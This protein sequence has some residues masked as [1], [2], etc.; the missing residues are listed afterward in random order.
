MPFNFGIGQGLGRPAV[1]QNITVRRG[2]DLGGLVGGTQLDD[3]QAQSL[4]LLQAMPALQQAG[5]QRTASPMGSIAGNLIPIFGAMIYAKAAQQQAAAKAQQ[6]AFENAVTVAKLQQG[7]A[8]RTPTNYQQAAIQALTQGDYGKFDMFT[9]LAKEQGS[10]KTPSTIGLVQQANPNATPQQ[11]LDKL[12]AF[13]AQSQTA[14]QAAKAPGVIDQF[15]QEQQIKEGA[16]KAPPPEL[17][18]TWVSGL[19]AIRS[20]DDAIKGFA[21]TTPA[22]ILK[23]TLTRGIMSNQAL[24][25][26]NKFFNDID[27]LRAGARGMTAAALSRVSSELPNPKMAIPDP[28]GFMTQLN[29]ARANFYKDFTTGLLIE[30]HSYKVPPELTGMAAALGQPKKDTSSQDAVDQVMGSFTFHVPPG[31]EAEATKVVD[32]MIRAKKSDSDIGQALQNLY[33]PQE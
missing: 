1:N 29:Q 23:G 3:S 17:T 14:N 19:A 33:G 24:R 20:L 28:A 27:N 26:Y 2:P 11:L 31:K 8:A 5:L 10:G 7:G 12:A 4:A 13:N 18:K 9:Q 6:Q 16:L 25:D 21:T 22:D 30:G 32:Q 15:R